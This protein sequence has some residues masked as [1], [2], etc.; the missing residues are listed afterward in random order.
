[1]NIKNRIIGLLLV[2]ITI[3]TMISPLTPAYAV[4]GGDGLG[5]TTSTGGSSSGT[6][7]SSR[8]GIRVYVVDKNGNLVSNIVDVISNTAIPNYR[9]I[10]CLGTRGNGT[11]QSFAAGGLYANGVFNS[12]TNSGAKVTIISDTTPLPTVFPPSRIANL[13]PCSIAIGVINSIVIS[14]LSPGITISVPAG[15]SI[16]PVTSVVLK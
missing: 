9:I 7:S 8:T 4:G 2:L 16:N 1:M 3:F 14:T 5:N 15:K 10:A 6:W 12:S 11:Y 13:N